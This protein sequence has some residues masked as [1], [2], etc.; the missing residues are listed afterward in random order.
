[1]HE[2]EAGK[3][4][5]QQ[6]HRGWPNEV[7]AVPMETVLREEKRGLVCSSGTRRLGCGVWEDAGWDGAVRHAAAPWGNPLTL[8]GWGS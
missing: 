1:M 8:S 4:P 3:P 2:R 5:P 6:Q 7:D